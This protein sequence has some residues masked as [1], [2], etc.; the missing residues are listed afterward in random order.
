MIAFLVNL[1]LILIAPRHTVALTDIP[2]GDH[3]A[4]ESCCSK[5]QERRRG[6]QEGGRCGG[7]LDATAV[8]RGDGSAS[9]SQITAGGPT[10]SEAQE[11][12]RVAAERTA[13]WAK[14]DGLEAR[15]E[16]DAAIMRD[17]TRQ[18][19]AQSSARNALALDVQR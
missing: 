13:L 8:A 19:M 5:G 2:R 3:A 15:W 1:F 11:L 6:Q 12:G 17:M 9:Y 14:V 10:A 7:G 4:Q 16:K 18:Y